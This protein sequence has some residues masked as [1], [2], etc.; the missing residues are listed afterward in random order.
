MPRAIKAKR[1]PD[2]I[3]DY[4]IKDLERMLKM[5]PDE[6]PR[7]MI[8]AAILRKEGNICGDTEKILKKSQ[9]TIH[10][11]LVRLEEGG[12]VPHTSGQ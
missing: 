5:L 10:D 8:H 12:F 9:S 7:M 6:K 11:W 4:K 2:Y 1:G 3:A